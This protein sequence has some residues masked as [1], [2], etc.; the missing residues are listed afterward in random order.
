M[1]SLDLAQSVNQITQEHYHEYP[2]FV[3]NKLAH[4]VAMMLLNNVQL[5]EWLGSMQPLDLF[6][7]VC[8]AIDEEVKHQ[9]QLAAKED[10]RAY[11][12]VLME[13][14]VDVICNHQDLE[15]RVMC[16]KLVG[17]YVAWTDIQL[18]ANE[19]VLGVLFTCLNLDELRVAALGCFVEV[20]NKGMRPSDKLEF[21]TQL[22]LHRHIGILSIGNNTDVDCAIGDLV[23]ATGSELCLI[24]E[25]DALA[26]GAWVQLMSYLPFVFSLFSIRVTED[27]TD[28]D[29][30]MTVVP[31][32]SAFL[33]LLR[34]E[35]KRAGG[36]RVPIT[37][38]LEHFMNVILLQLKYPTNLPIDESFFEDKPYDSTPNL[39][40]EEDPVS[41]FLEKRRQM[42]MLL[43][44]L[45]NVDEN[46]VMSKLE[47]AISTVFTRW[48]EVDGFETLEMGLYLLF[49]L[50]EA[51]GRQAMIPSTAERQQSSA[52]TELTR[53][54]KLVS[55]L[56][57]KPEM[58]T[59]PHP[60]IPYAYMDC[61]I[62]YAMFFN[63]AVC[64]DSG[65]SPMSLLSGV[66]STLV[67]QRGLSSPV[68]GVRRKAM[69]CLW[70]LIR[71]T[72][73]ANGLRGLASASPAPTGSDHNQDASHQLDQEMRAQ[74]IQW[75]C[76]AVS[77]Y[78]V[79]LL[80]T[81]SEKDALGSGFEV[82]G[83]MA[84]SLDLAAGR[85]AILDPL[86]TSTLQ[87]IEAALKSNQPRSV[88]DVVRCIF[89]LGCL[90]KGYGEAQTHRRPP[91]MALNA[92]SSSLTPPHQDQ[93]DHVLLLGTLKHVLNLVSSLHHLGPIR[94]GVRQAYHRFVTCLSE[95]ALEYLPSLTRLLL[96]LS[97][98]S[99]LDHQHQHQNQQEGQ[100]G[101]EQGRVQ[102][103]EVQDYL[104]FLSALIYQNKK[105]VIL[106]S[107]LHAILAMIGPVVHASL[108][109]LACLLGAGG[110]GGSAGGSADASGGMMGTE[111]DLREMVELIKC[112]ISFLNI[113]IESYRS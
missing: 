105:S 10:L 34:K 92:A 88:G 69:T 29:P 67:D 86:I 24:F 5:M 50:G 82:V 38:Y 14:W 71:T 98:S 37:E 106:G 15:S 25:E 112:T 76:Q 13:R 19:R 16:L 2:S 96:L 94:D 3:K 7:R 87:A 56:M 4:I 11:M 12:P 20:V 43:D 104:N 111:D 42:R 81:A 57:S 83:L 99:S 102:V 63:L 52:P 70:R 61:V 110:S 109:E 45:L 93:S 77:P 78:C 51:K 103:N 113:Y 6:L 36:S 41:A 95:P 44:V 97:P 21:L 62:R 18:V 75:F 40:K 72:V 54:G 66:V 79:D 1:T 85:V 73:L 84:A 48:N 30:C 26:E 33:S 89:A 46:F 90:A 32:T 17:M 28:D 60:A 64:L 80:A 68:A 58:T 91:S 27:T 31:F 23:S 39:T 74:F 101:Q 100:E 107:H 55:L 65:S 9:P 22:A 47:A 108:C 8:A 53:M 49:I 35:T 59:Y